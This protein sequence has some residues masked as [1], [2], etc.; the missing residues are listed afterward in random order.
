MA[1][2]GAIEDDGALLRAKLNV[3]VQATTLL[4]SEFVL[5]LPISTGESWRDVCAA[6][7]FINAVLPQFELAV[8]VQLSYPATARPVLPFTGSIEARFRILRALLAMEEHRGWTF[9]C[10]FDRER[11]FLRQPDLEVYTFSEEP[12][13]IQ[14]SIQWLARHG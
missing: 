13:I 12:I 1:G 10:R 2:G 7:T 3:L 6:L 5:H 8:T 4:N 11:L 9:R 14:P